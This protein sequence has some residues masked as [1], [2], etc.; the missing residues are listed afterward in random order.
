MSDY[1]KAGVIQRRRQLNSIQNKIGH[2]VSFLAFKAVIIAVAAVTIMGAACAVGVFKGVLA[3][4][5]DIGNIDVT[6][7]G[8]STF[9][10]DVQGNQ[11]A[12]L[13]STDSNRIPVAMAQVPENLQHAFVAIEDERFYQ[14]NGI[15]IKGI[16]RAGVNGVTSG[17]FDQGASTITQQLIKNNVF[18]QWASGETFTEKVKRKIQEQYL[19]VELEKNMSKEDI[20]INYMNSI[21]L[22]QNTL[23]VQAAALRYFSKDV[24]TLN[25]SECAVIAAITQN[26]SRYNPISRP[27]KNAERRE[28]VLDKMLELGFITQEEHDQAMEDDVYSRIQ[29]VDTK[30]TDDTINSYFVDALTDDVLADLTAMGYTETQAYTLLYSGG[31]K[32]YSTQDSD[33]QRICDSVCMDESNFPA[34]TKWYLNYRLTI[35]RASGDIENVSTEMFRQYYKEVKGSSYNLIYNSQDSA[36][37]D[38]EAYKENVM[39][40]GDTV[41]AETVSLTPQP[42]ISFTIENQSTGEVLAMIG[43][44]GAKNAS[45]TLNRATDT[46]R[47]PG[48]TFK[49]VS[50]YAPALDAAGLTLATVQIDQPF[51]YNNGRPVKNADGKFRGITSL[52]EG[53]RDSVNIVAVKTLTQITPQ[54]GFE[55]LKNFGFTTLVESRKGSDGLVYSDI[56]QA[57]ALGGLTDGVTNEELNAAYACIANG[58]VYNK[59]RLYTK[60]VDHDGNVIVDNTQP[61]T[62]RVLKETTAWLLTSAMQDVVNGGTGARCNFGTTAIAGKTGTTSSYN[63][64]WF[65]GYTTYYTGTSWAGYDNNVNLTSTDEK[66]LAKNIWRKC[67]EQ[68]HA[69][70]PSTRFPA[71][72]AGIVAANVCHSSGKIPVAGLC[73]GDVRTE[74]FAEGTVPQ[75]TCDVHYQGYLCAVDHCTATEVCPFKYWGVLTKLPQEDPSVL[76]GSSTTVVATDENGNPVFVTAGSQTCHHNAA[77]FATPGYENII[78]QEQAALA[79]SGSQITADYNNAQQAGEEPIG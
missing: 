53:I 58:G 34:D 60:I 26:P 63:D 27:E 50:T 14:H 76:S 10:Y 62:R 35:Q 25:L 56:Q 66:N 20:L 4:A 40:S 51:S 68:I 29:E 19:A 37:E 33:I 49:I 65:A 18:T 78:S 38:I 57:L 64:S 9:V 30:T 16:I 55:Y 23:G 1:G 48:S 28:K 31:L 43:G 44:R 13:V 36:Y 17:N 45:R 15:D 41:Q 61:E 77:F 46:K 79:A 32:I 69:G 22:G 12:K 71:P 39:R 3:S 54:L 72:P 2:K 42:Q 73:D 7:S 11:T 74:Y 52:R 24:S 59:P 75:T 5:P 21:N 47:Q 67:M 70:L 6:P 8:Y